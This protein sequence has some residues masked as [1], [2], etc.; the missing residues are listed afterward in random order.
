VWNVG[1]H[2]Q[3][4]ADLIH[5]CHPR[6]DKRRPIRSL[7]WSQVAAPGLSTGCGTA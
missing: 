4:E 6:D 2:A 5:R 3:L 7:C 1:E